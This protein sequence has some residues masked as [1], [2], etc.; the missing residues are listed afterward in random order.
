MPWRCQEPASF[1]LPQ[2]YLLGTTLL[3]LLRPPRHCQFSR[4]DQ[5]SP[6]HLNLYLSS[7]SDFDRRALLPRPRLRILHTLPTRQLAILLV[8]WYH[9]RHRVRKK[10]SSRELNSWTVRHWRRGIFSNMCRNIGTSKAPNILF[11]KVKLSTLS[12]RE[13]VFQSFLVKRKIYSDH[14]E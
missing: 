11:S 13:L 3:P 7:S 10:T 14:V 9:R 4:G 6:L 12:Y 5:S 8:R 1:D 2:C